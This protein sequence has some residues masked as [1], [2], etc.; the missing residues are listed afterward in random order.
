M[1]KTSTAA[2]GPAR[3][4]L[5]GSTASLAGA[6]ALLAAAHYPNHVRPVG[7]VE[8]MI[9]GLGGF[10]LPIAFGL[11]NNWTELWTSCLMLLFLVVAGNLLSMHVA[12]LRMEHAAT[13]RIAVSN[14]ALG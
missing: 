6:T 12:V 7:S 4:P 8:G 10:V 3:R 9:G 5:L 1:P 13:N 11:L 2:A 14:K